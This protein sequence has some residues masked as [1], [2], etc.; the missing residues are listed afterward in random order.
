MRPFE[1][2][3]GNS[4]AD[5]LGML[6]IRRENRQKNRM[7]D[8]SLPR[9]YIDVMAIKDMKHSARRFEITKEILEAYLDTDPG[10]TEIL[11]GLAVVNYAQGEFE[12][13]V[14]ILGRVLE[15]EPVNDD[16]RT[17]LRMIGKEKKRV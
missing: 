13:A 17:F 3:K 4:L 5:L 15:Y 6:D 14:E 1:G 12:T 8:I 16:A 7:E 9:C 10:N 11:I 2:K